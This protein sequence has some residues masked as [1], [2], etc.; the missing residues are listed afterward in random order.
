MIGI[1]KA[2]N[3]FNTFL[4][5]IYGLLLKLTWFLHPHIPVVHK[6]DGFLFREILSKLQNTGSEIPVI[7]P[8]ITY[9]LLFTQAY[10]SSSFLKQINIIHYS[11]SRIYLEIIYTI[12]SMVRLKILFFEI[13]R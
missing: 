13:F 10:H 8:A 3:P 9:I 12:K 5:F 1:F 6:T 11:F 7:Y 2:N 4:L